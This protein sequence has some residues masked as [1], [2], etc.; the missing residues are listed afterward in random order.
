MLMN[1]GTDVCDEL[2]GK[3]KMLRFE[4]LRSFHV[5]LNVTTLTDLESALNQPESEH[6]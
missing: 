6:I 3:M 1:L 2:E 5:V 4:R